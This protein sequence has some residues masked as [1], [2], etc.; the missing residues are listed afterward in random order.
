MLNYFIILT[1]N[2]RA[3]GSFLQL[4]VVL[5]LGV[6]LLFRGL[7]LL[8]FK[9][10][11]INMPTS[12]I[13]SL[14]MG[15]VEIYGQV[16]KGEE[17]LKSPINKK[18]C[19]YYDLHIE[20]FVRRGKRSRWV[21]L[22]REDD[23]RLFFL[24]DGSGKIIIDSQNAEYN[25]KTDF[26]VQTGLFSEMPEIVKEYC[27]KEDISKGFLGIKPRLRFTEKYIEPNN[28][29]YILGSAVPNDKKDILGNSNSIKIGKDSS[30]PFYYISDYSEKEL[31]KGYIWKVPLYILGG[32][33]III[34]IFPLLIEIASKNRYF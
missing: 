31:L 27:K 25:F 26:K 28:S 6:L 5:G 13:K 11:I 33:S 8:K 2:I 23:S 17:L 19:V 16:E 15:F 29:L 14:A 32:A 34:V 9:R 30:H 12:K 10:M 4:L 3:D 1:S 24:N 21:T 7:K 18:D 22:K 20:K